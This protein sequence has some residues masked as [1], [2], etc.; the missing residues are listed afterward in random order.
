[1]TLAALHSLHDPAPINRIWKVGAVQLGHP[2]VN[3]EARALGCRRE[4]PRTRALLSS[5]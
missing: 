5:V 3:R 2:L 4:R 1:L